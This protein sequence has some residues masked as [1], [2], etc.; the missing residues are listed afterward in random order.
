MIHWW[1][2]LIALLAGAVFGI[3]LLAVLSG[4]KDE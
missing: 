2:V 3:L 4:G 1:W